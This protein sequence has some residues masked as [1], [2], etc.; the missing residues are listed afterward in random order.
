MEKV[1]CNSLVNKESSPEEG[2]ELTIDGHDRGIKESHRHREKNADVVGIK[3]MSKE[4]RDI[5]LA[6]MK[7]ELSHLEKLLLKGIREKWKQGF[8]V[9]RR[10]KWPVRELFAEKLLLRR[11]GNEEVEYI[12]EPEKGP[13]LGDEDSDDSREELIYADQN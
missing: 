9:G 4:E 7:A 12:C 1:S 6:E 11:T 2:K 5:E 10:V 8:Y 13:L 3:G